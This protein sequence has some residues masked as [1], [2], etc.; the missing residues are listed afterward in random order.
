MKWFWKKNTSTSSQNPNGDRSK[1]LNN[2]VPEDFLIHYKKIETIFSSLPVPLASPLID[3]KKFL[4]ILLWTSPLTYI[5]GFTLSSTQKVNELLRS[6]NIMIYSWRQWIY[7]FNTIY[8]PD[9]SKRENIVKIWSIPWHDI[10]AEEISRIKQDHPDDPLLT[11]NT[12]TKQF[13]IRISSYPPYTLLKESIMTKEKLIKQSIWVETVGL[14]EL[15]YNW[16]DL[17]I[18]EHDKLFTILLCNRQRFFTTIKNNS[19][20]TKLDPSFKDIR[21]M[22]FFAKTDTWFPLFESF[23]ELY[24]YVL[25]EHTYAYLN[26]LESK[27]IVLMKLHKVFTYS[28]STT[29]P[30]QEWQ[31]QLITKKWTFHIPLP[32]AIAINVAF[33]K[34]IFIS[35]SIVRNIVDQDIFKVKKTTFSKEILFSYE[36]QLIDAIHN[37]HFEQAT[38]LREKITTVIDTLSPN[39]LE[40]IKQEIS[41]SDKDSLLLKLINKS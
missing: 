23:L 36:Q 35:D 24:R 25:P 19:I 30:I 11:N 22:P 5:S 33:D 18:T 37:E 40:A 38:L 12:Y 16:V 39:E 15:E 8:S 14:Q 17:Q 2:S 1:E 10:I 32:L 27:D 28:S 13:D 41:S 6:Y 3:N 7:V 34:K 20:R 4:H 26:N 9:A 31:V 21:N 29:W